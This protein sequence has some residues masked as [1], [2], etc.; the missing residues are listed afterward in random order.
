MI[1]VSFINKERMNEIL[2][3]EKK[4][5]KTSFIFLLFSTIRNTT[6]DTFNNCLELESVDKWGDWT[7]YVYKKD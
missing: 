1:G 3:D 5:N 2:K 6:L 7:L 4:Y